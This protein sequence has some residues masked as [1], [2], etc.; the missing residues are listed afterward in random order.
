MTAGVLRQILRG[1]PDEAPIYLA[2][3][4]GPSAAH[5]VTLVE[6]SVGKTWL[7]WSTRRGDGETDGRWVDLGEGTV[8]GVHLHGAG[9]AGTTVDSAPEGNLINVY[10]PAGKLHYLPEGSTVGSDSQFVGFAIGFGDQHL[11]LHDEAVALA[12]LLNDAA[13]EGDLVRRMIALGVV[14]KIAVEQIVDAAAPV[15]GEFG[16]LVTAAAATTGDAPGD[17]AI[18]LSFHVGDSD[19]AGEIAPVLE[20]DFHLT[21][22]DLDLDDAT[23]DEVAREVRAFLTARKTTVG[24]AG[25]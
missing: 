10:G 14:D 11:L 1:V 25:S 24:E 18:L 9:E 19:V 4:D 16:Y 21:V 5:E 6:E 8:G 12:L 7:L 15:A 23:R 22:V 13:A 2:T 17:R 20:L 3:P